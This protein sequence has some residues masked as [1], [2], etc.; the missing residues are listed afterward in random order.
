[1]EKRPQIFFFFFFSHFFKDFVISVCLKYSKMKIIFFY[2]LQC[3]ALICQ[4]CGSQIMDQIALGQS[5]Y[6]TLQSAVTEEIM[7]GSS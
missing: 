4:N 1:M 3:N 7:E 6:M 2:I 5:D